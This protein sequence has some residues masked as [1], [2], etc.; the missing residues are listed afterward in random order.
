MAS[1]FTIRMF[2]C[3]AIP[4]QGDDHHEGTLIAVA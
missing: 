1:W 4:E 2:V 3:Q